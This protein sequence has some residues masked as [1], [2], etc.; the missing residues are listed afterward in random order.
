MSSS[1]C[2][3]FRVSRLTS[4]QIKGLLETMTKWSQLMVQARSLTLTQQMITTLT[5]SMADQFPKTVN[6]KKRQKISQ[7]LRSLILLSLRELMPNSSCLT[8]G[9]PFLASCTLQSGS[10]ESKE[11]RSLPTVSQKPSSSLTTAKTHSRPPKEQASPRS[12]DATWQSS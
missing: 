5:W 11:F 8:T 10:R 12:K 1:Q 3:T 6:S 4:H 9:R 2:K 7:S